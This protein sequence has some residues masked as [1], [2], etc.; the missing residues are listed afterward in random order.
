MKV[1]KFV[2]KQAVEEVVISARVEKTMA[3]KIAAMAK[4]LKISKSE[5]IKACIRMGLEGK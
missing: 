4:A 3:E 2:H 5:F 1:E